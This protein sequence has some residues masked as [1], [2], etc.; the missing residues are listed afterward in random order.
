MSSQL[1][2]RPRALRT[3]CS[4]G[5]RRQIGRGGFGGVD[6]MRGGVFGGCWA[7]YGGRGKRLRVDFVSCNLT[8]NFA[9]PI[10]RDIDAGWI[11]AT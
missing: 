2:Q 10:A 7:T 6:G 3:S 11:T 1:K 9:K 8:S 4:A 5:E